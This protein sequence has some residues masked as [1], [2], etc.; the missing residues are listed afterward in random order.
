M[1][2]LIW[3]LEK[4]VYLNN[5]KWT[6]FKGFHYIHFSEQTMKIFFA[7]NVSWLLTLQCLSTVHGIQWKIAWIGS[8]ACI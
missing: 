6:L 4:N 2:N 8:L 1:L 3:Q 7:Q 5:N